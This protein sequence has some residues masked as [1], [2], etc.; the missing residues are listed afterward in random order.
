LLLQLRMGLH[1]G[2]DLWAG[3]SGVVR[4]AEIEGVVLMPTLDDALAALAAWQASHA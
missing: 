2:V 1:A 3:G 4:L